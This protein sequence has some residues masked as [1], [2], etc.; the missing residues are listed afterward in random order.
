[1]SDTWTVFVDGGSR[2]NP[3]PAAFGYHI[4]DPAGT[5][6]EHSE[7]IGKATNNHAEYRGLVAALERCLELGAKRVQVSSD[8]ELMVKQMTGEYRVKNA[9]LLP[10]YERADDSRH[11]FASFTIRH[12]YRK[13]NARA[14]EL[15]NL[16][17]DGKPVDAVR[18]AG[19]VVRAEVA[20]PKAAAKKKVV[21]ASAGREAVV[22]FLREVAAVWRHGEGPT[23]EQV[24]DSVWEILADAG[25]LKAK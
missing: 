1:M 17:L 16:A 4:T 11:Q 5:V 8:S 7:A 19:T 9:E 24:A 14:D 3:G 20:K 23:P 10:W 21:S 15:C 6:Y 2:G 13:D 25:A 22:E 12:V 18:A